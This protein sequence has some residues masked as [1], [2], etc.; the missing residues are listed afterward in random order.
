MLTFYVSY[1][2][3][4]L[5]DEEGKPLKWNLIVN[6]LNAKI[7]EIKEKTNSDSYHLYIT[8]DNNFRKKEATI[9]PYK[10]NRKDV[11]KPHAYERVK[12]YLS[13]GNAHPVTVTDWYE[14]DDALS[15]EQYSTAV[16]NGIGGLDG[17]WEDTVIC[18][19]DKDLKMIPG[20][21]YGWSVS[22]R[23]KEKPLY[24]VSEEQG[25]IWFFTQLLTGDPTDNIPGLYR[26]GPSNA[27]K[28]LEGLTEPLSLYSKVQG[29][30]EARFGSY[31]RMFMH[32]NAR[33]LWMLR[34]EDDDIRETLDEFENQR[35]K[36]DDEVPF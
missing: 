26:V 31:W 6:H 33:L 30:Y 4:S 18:S 1:Q 35:N 16:A 22:D 11:E 3:G 12:G 27:K 15:I 28:L 23:I 9:K 24:F 7:Q 34:S 14:A 19:N 20:Y 17:C 21:H 2:Y 13:S 29:E 5:L 8:G 10:G 36:E 25:W 32:E